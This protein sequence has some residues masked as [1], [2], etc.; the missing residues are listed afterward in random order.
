MIPIAFVDDYQPIRSLIINLM[1]QHFPDIYQFYEYENGKVFTERFPT[2][3]YTPA[4]VLMD[5]SMP[6]MNGYD[7]TAWIK[8]KF[9]TI[10]VLIFS[11]IN[12]PDSLCLFVRC[13][14][15][16]YICK[17]E[18]SEKNKLN[19]AINKII[20]GENY[21]KNPDLYAFAKK[22][23]QMSLKELKEGID[24]LNEQEMQ[25]VRYLTAQK[26]IIQKADELCISPSGYKKRLCKVFKKLK[27]DSTESLYK[28]AVSVGLI[29]A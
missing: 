26:T 23:M 13:G 2:E 15:D 9:P 10:P 12:R 5:L 16:G 11:D 4:I 27:V 20:A 28:Y 3:N 17:Q 21:M 19:L 22:R 1:N 18:V 24:S 6:E 14:A 7:T 8:E 29:R 25:L